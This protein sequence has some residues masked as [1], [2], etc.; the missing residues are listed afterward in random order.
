AGLN[1]GLAYDATMTVLLA[2]S[3]LPAGDGSGAELAEAIGRLADPSGTPISFGQGASFIGAVQQ[4]LSAGD[5]V[6]LR[7][8]SGELDYVLDTG[9]LRR[10]LT[11]WDVEPIS[12]TTAPRL[13]A[14]RRYALDPAPAVTG[15]WMDL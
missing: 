7:G 14:R 5:S 3:A 2:L 15:T 10:E 13:R 4:A 8:V 12:G 9:D 6:D 1:A 11:G